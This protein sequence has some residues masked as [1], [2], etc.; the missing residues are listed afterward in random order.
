MLCEN[1]CGYMAQQ[2]IYK[3]QH[4]C[5]PT[6][7]GKSLHAK[8]VLKRVAEAQDEPPTTALKTQRSFSPSEAMAFHSVTK[9]VEMHRQHAV[10][11]L[12]LDSHLEAK[13][14]YKIKARL[15]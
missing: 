3:L 6:E 2:R 8:N 14:I 10:D 12:W 13:E 1:K 5:T 9:E 11:T 15:R 4:P 7:H